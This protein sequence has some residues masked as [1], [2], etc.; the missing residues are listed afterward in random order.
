VTEF[1]FYFKT[2]KIFRESLLCDILSLILEKCRNMGK[3]T[4]KTIAGK[5]SSYSRTGI[6]RA[7]EAPTKSPGKRTRGGNLIVV[8]NEDEHDTKEGIVRWL[9]GSIAVGSSIESD[10]DMITTG[11]AGIPKSS[12][13]IL[14]T[15]IGVSRKNMAENILEVSVKTLERKSPTDKLDKKI[16]S[17]ALEIAKLMQHAYEVFEDEEKAKT[18]MSRENRALNGKKPVEL[19]DTLT[20]LNMVNDVLGRI[21]EGVYS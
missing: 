18:W 10:F 17:H 8:K 3:Q 6:V 14:C 16:S 12:L 4:E 7:A 5:K 2:L 11:S 21:E 20:G 1:I 13:D 19:F 9:G 15:Y